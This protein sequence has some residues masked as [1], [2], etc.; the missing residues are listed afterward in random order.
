MEQILLSFQ[1]MQR[2]IPIIACFTGA[3]YYFYL[4]AI[5]RWNKTHE[6]SA[7]M[8]AKRPDINE[9]FHQNSP[10]RSDKQL[11][12]GSALQSDTKKETL[13]S[14]RCKHCFDSENQI[15]TT[16]KS[17]FDINEEHCGEDHDK[18]YET[19]LISFAVVFAILQLPKQVYYWMDWYTLNFT[20]NK[21]SIRTIMA[22]QLIK[23]MANCFL[24]VQWPMLVI[25][26]YFTCEDVRNAMV[27]LIHLD[28]SHC[29]CFFCGFYCDTG[30]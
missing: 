17:Q 28:Q 16:E 6:Q 23:V 19:F 29:H 12:N 27:K 1:V 3:L 7:E 4:L 2:S 13:R 5:M 26:G 15:R 10:W 21:N 18:R 9:A 22:T 25:I 24:L 14:G 30:S 20:Y 8:N 11:M